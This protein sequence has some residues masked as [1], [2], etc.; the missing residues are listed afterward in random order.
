MMLFGSSVPVSPPLMADDSGRRTG[1]KGGYKHLGV[2]AG[3][4]QADTNTWVCPPVA[5]RRIQ[6]LGCAR[7]WRPKGPPGG[8]KHLGAPAGG[9]QADT[10]TWVYPPSGRGADKKTLGCIPPM[11]TGGGY[12]WVCQPSQ[13]MFTHRDFGPPARPQLG[14][15]CRGSECGLAILCFISAQGG[16]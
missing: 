13:T 16:I 8:Y 9:H 4:H 2:P 7:P 6:T 11:G 12:T 15:L 3:V 1:E 5:T 10:N 14:S